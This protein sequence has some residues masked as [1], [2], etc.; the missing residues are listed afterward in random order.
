MFEVWGVIRFK[1]AGRA[2]FESKKDRFT[3][4]VFALPSVETHPS[5]YGASAAL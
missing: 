5:P 1:Q 4:G 3:V 2:G